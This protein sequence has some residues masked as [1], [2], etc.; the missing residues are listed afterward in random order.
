MNKLVDEIIYIT[1]CVK[2]QYEKSALLSH[3]GH[4]V[5]RCRTLVY[6]L[7]KNWVL[8]QFTHNFNGMK[9]ITITITMNHCF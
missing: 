9:I 2:L 7:V 1:W 6:E 5:S 8:A 3:L 4:R